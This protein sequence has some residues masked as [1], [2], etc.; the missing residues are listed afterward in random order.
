MVDDEEQDEKGEKW[1]FVWY[2][3]KGFVSFFSLLFIHDAK[4]ML[5]KTKKII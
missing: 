4:N 3:W 2:N 5:D 1:K